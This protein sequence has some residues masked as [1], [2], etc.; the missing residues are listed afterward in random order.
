LSR[1]LIF[2]G[3]L[4]LNPGSFIH[5]ILIGE[6]FKG[7]INYTASFGL[8]TTGLFVPLAMVLPYI[9]AFYLV[10][11]FMEDSGYLPRLSIL[12]DNIMHTVACSFAWVVMSLVF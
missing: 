8:L 12:V 6:L 3:S 9:F 1:G 11:S 5:K 7:E 10:L 4:I 2:Y